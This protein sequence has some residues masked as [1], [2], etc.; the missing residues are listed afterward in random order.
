VR[1]EPAFVFVPLVLSP[2]IRLRLA[3]LGLWQLRRWRLFRLVLRGWR[4]R[5]WGCSTWEVVWVV[6]GG[7]EHEVASLW[8]DVWQVK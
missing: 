3:V 5:T 1:L 8:V 6:E 4:H 7:W 2:E